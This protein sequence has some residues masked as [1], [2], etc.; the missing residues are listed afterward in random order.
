MIQNGKWFNRRKNNAAK[1]SINSRLFIIIRKVAVG[2]IDWLILKFLKFWIAPC[3]RA[4]KHTQIQTYRRTHKYIT[5]PHPSLSQSLSPQHTCTHKHT[6]FFHAVVVSILLYGCTTWMLTKRIEK[7]LDVNYKR[8]LRAILSFSWS[9]H[10]TKQLMYG[11]LP[12]I[13]KTIKIR[14]TRHAGYCWRSRDELISDLLLWTPLHGRAN[15]GQPARTYIQ[16]L[17]PERGCR[18]EDLPEAVD[19]REWWWK[20]VRDIRVYDDDIVIFLPS[21]RAKC[22][23]RWC[24]GRKWHIPMAVMWGNRVGGNWMMKWDDLK[25]IPMVHS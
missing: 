22:H 3:I 7:K 2:K 17:W 25:K 9:Q 8:I 23:L 10:L 14:W 6:H 5:E 19:D 24:T 20:R 15:A 4:N 13:T 18:P 21:A 12:P 11:H 1:R 16:Q